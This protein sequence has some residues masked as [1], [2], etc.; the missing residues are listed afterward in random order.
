[1]KYPTKQSYSKEATVDYPGLIQI[2]TQAEATAGVSTNKAVTPS[3]LAAASTALISDATTTVAGKIEIATAAEAQ[4]KTESDKAIV[5]SN[6]NSPGFLQWADVT[7]DAT[8]IKAL[9]TT[10]IELVAAPSTGNSILFLGA[11]LKLNY[12]G[13]NAFSESGDNLGIKYTDDSGVQVCTTIECTNFIDATADTYTNAVPSADNIVAASGAEAEA[14][15]LDNLGNN[16]SG[17]AA[18]DNT[19]TVRVYYVVQAL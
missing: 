5:P 16:F 4:A 12:G 8:E 11:L 6:L 9:A 19:M 7:L 18:N 10:Q 14:L 3:S 13:N 15:V 17:N 1:M 2:A